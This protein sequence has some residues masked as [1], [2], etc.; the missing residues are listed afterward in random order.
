MSTFAWDPARD[1]ANRRK[2]G[3]RFADA[4]LAFLDPRRVIARDVMHSVTEERY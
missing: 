4:Q 3:V 1:V 2:H